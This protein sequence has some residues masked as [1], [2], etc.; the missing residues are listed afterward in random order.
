MADEPNEFLET[1]EP[2]I[3]DHPSMANFKSPSDVAKAWVGAQSI[4]GAD[5][6]AIPSKED[7]PN[8]GTLYNKLG[9]PEKHEGYKF[10]EIEG[11]SPEFV[12]PENMAK[13][14]ERFHAAGLS[15]KAADS[16]Y[17]DFV[18]D[19]AGIQKEQDSKGAASR[20]AS[21]KALRG[22]LGLAYD[23]NIALADKTLKFM[24]GDKSKEIGAKFGNDPD[25]IRG[26]IKIGGELSEDILGS[27]T[28]PPSEMTP[29]AAQKEINAAYGN[30]EHP[31]LQANH[32]EHK[33]WV[34]DRM[35]QLMMMANPGAE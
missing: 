21:E 8:W 3:K 33:F 35:P 20:D 16:I 28:P 27:G 25:F 5:K 19:M 9:R 18:T 13:W 15:N 7:D 24:Y 17:R 1:L 22:E 34:E 4:I 29:D 14:K 6:I 12:K 32:P 2:G 30:P 26:M 23:A 11:V 31:F 10:G